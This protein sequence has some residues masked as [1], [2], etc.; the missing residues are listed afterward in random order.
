M[1][2]VC[3]AGTNLPWVC[4]PVEQPLAVDAAGAD[5]DLRLPHVV[6]GALGVGGRVVERAEPVHL[7]VLEHTGLHRDER[8][9]AAPT[10][11]PTTQ[12]SGAPDTATT[13]S[14]IARDDQR[15]AEVRLQHD[16]AERY[17]GERQGEHHVDVARRV[18]GVALLRQQHRQADDQRDLRELRRLDR[19]AGRQHDPGVRA[20]DG[21]ARAATAPPP[22]RRSRART[23]PA[24]RPAASGSRTPR[25]PRP[26]RARSRRSGCASSGTPCGSPP[27][28]S[29]ACRVADQTS[30]PPSAH[31]ASTASSS[32][33]SM[34]RS[35]ESRCSSRAARRSGGTVYGV[36]R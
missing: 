12:R 6:A 15:G 30:A 23:G 11:R 33:Q 36:G 10:T 25:P 18:L 24:R 7:V 35:A 22:G 17:G 27:E 29:A 5:R 16:Q 1:K 13:P 32:V 19:E 3:C 31:S 9:Q 28:S 8:D 21:R 14:T 26:A 4:A 20:V 2:S 34:R